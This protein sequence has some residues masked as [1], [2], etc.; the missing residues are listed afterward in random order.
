MERNG[1]A[2]KLELVGGMFEI[3][4]MS[5]LLKKFEPEEGEDGKKK[6]LG[7]VKFNAIV[8]QIEGLLMKGNQAVA[9]KLIAMNKE[10][11]VDEVQK[12]SDVDYTNALKTAIL[13]DVL[14]FFA[15]SPRTDGKN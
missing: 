13:T 3:D 10:I 9:D 4:G 11:S 2:E 5:D 7:A 12:L 6:M 1:L 8:I 14:G 15:S